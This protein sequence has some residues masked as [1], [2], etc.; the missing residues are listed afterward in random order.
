MAECRVKV[1]W[2]GRRI[3]LCGLT[4]GASDAVYA[5]IECYHGRGCRI[6][7][8]LGKGVEDRML[9]GAKRL[10]DAIKE[11]NAIVEYRNGPNAA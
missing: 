5:E 2:L 1:K 3:A 10:S 7:V 9:L 6:Y 8:L 11:V 4:N